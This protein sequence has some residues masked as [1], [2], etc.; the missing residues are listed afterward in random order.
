LEYSFSA[1]LWLYSGEGAWYFITLPKEYAK[2]IKSLITAPRKGFGSLR[3][4]AQ[5]GSTTWTT[6]IFPD[7]KTSSYLLPV[8]KEVRAENNLRIDETVKVRLRIVDL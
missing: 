3:V 1:K 6:S 7:K 4:K 8:K 2:E 5:I